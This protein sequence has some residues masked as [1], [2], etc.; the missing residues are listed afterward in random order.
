MVNYAQSISFTHNYIKKKVK[1]IFYNILE[2]FMDYKES[3]FYIEKN[4]KQIDKFRKLCQDLPDY[5]AKFLQSKEFDSSYSTLIVYAY[6]LNLFFEFL[7]KSNPQLKDVELKNIQIECLEQLNEDDFLEFQHYLRKTTI[8][9]KVHTNNNKSI[10]RKITSLRGLF[11]F[12]KR[13]N[14]IKYDI[15]GS[16]PVP[17][18]NDRK[19][20]IV[21]L[22]TEQ[23]NNELEQFLVGV[24]EILENENISDHQKNYLARDYIRD[25]ALIYIFLGTGIRLSE[26]EGLDVSDVD[27]DNK[28]LRI[29]RK[30]GFYDTV[31]FNDK[32]KDVV[33]EYLQYRNEKYENEES[34]ALL[35]TTSRKRMGVSAIRNVVK[36]YIKIIMLK[37]MTTHKLRAT[38]GSYLYKITGDIRLVADVLGHSNINTTAKY[39]ASQT[40]ENKRKAAEIDL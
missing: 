12:L 32:V 11:K 28:S 10:A 7:K 2:V 18:Y 36:K 17:K 29:K 3:K 31:Y 20:E 25:K 34:A 5:A 22:K 4:Q 9:G 19:T 35:L 33:D 26:C 21:R 6:D 39:Y 40:E 8:N 23:D 16:I 1:T 15:V 13:K 27:I 24:D 30:G 38:Y 37:H 14:Y